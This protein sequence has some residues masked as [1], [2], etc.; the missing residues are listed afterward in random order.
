MFTYT[1]RHKCILGYFMKSL[2]IA[3]FSVL[4]LS[5]YMTIA[6]DLYSDPFGNIYDE[7]SPFSIGKI[8]SGYEGKLHSDPFGSI[9]VGDSPFSIGEI[10]DASGR[11]GTVHRDD[12]G[13][14]YIG[15]S[16][17]ESEDIKDVLN[18]ED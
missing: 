10:H 3:T 17:F 1:L 7:D 2:K 15:S 13:H 6:G 12:F 8:E 18:I 16:P 9:Y 5:S 11:E 14:I 4:L